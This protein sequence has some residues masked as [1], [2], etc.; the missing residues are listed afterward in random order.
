MQN[1]PSTTLSEEIQDSGK[2]SHDKLPPIVIDSREKAPLVFGDY[3]TLR[4]KLD[5]GDYSLVGLE[6]LVAVERKSKE[7]AWL[8]ASN[9]TKSNPHGNRDRFV[10]CLERLAS[11]D[12]A[13]IVIECTFADFCVQPE[14]TRIEPAS[15][16]GSYYSW[17]AQ[18]RIPVFWPGSRAAAAKATMKL[19]AAYAKHC[20]Q[21]TCG[22]P[23]APDRG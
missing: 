6:H 1:T 9:G 23:T 16:V 4:A 14:H 22:L 5:A 11:L 17:A 8:C 19:L 20:H 15:V 13:F 18:Y 2:R 10:R 21:A 7:D 12:R 3:P